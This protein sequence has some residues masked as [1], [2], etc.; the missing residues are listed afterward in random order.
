MKKVGGFCHIRG[1]GGQRRFD[2]CHIWFFKGFPNSPFGFDLSK[3]DVPILD[4]VSGWAGL[5]LGTWTRACKYNNKKIIYTLPSCNPMT[6]D[7]L[8]NVCYHNKQQHE[9]LGLLFKYY[10]NYY[11]YIIQS[12]L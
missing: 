1:G 10:K 4:W 7:L 3:I 5:G 2:I 8:T 12:T 6:T 11:D 9:C